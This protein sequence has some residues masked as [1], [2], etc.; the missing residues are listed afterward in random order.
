M[1]W[2]GK[3]K[4]S[5]I[6]EQVLIKGEGVSSIRGIMHLLSRCGEKLN[7]WNKNS[8]VTVQNSLEKANK[9]LKRLQEIDL[10]YKKLGMLIKLEKKLKCG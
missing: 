3:T 7:R 5:N 2:V 10:K 4:C 9:L 1:K 8:F 6:I